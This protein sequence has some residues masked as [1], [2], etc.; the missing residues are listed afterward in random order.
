[1]RLIRRGQETSSWDP[2]REFSDLSTRLDRLLEGWPKLGAEREAMALADWSPRVDIRETKDAYLVDADLPGVDRQD[3]H[4]FVDDGMLTI[5]G[6]RRERREDKGARSHRVECS[7][8][9]FVRSFAVPGDASGDD[10]EAR[11]EAG[12]LRLRLP[13]TTAREATEVTIK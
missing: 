10:V 8:G 4:V 7:Y 6:E 13:R 2:F 12:V 1:M 11:F 5:R 3:V 9:T